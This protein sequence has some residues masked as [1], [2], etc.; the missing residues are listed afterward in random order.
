VWSEQGAPEGLHVWKP[1]AGSAEHVA[2]GMVA[3]VGPQPPPLPCVRCVPRQWV[4]T[5]TQAPRRVWESSASSGRIGRLLAQHGTGLLA[6]TG[7]GGAHLEDVE[8]FE[9]LKDRFF[10]EE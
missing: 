5:S 3:T 10:L 2:L 6:A 1:V 9:L 8:T 4:A 7:G